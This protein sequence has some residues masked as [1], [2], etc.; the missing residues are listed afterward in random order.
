MCLERADLVKKKVTAMGGEVASKPAGMRRADVVD[1]GAQAVSENRGTEVIRRKKEDEAEQINI[2]RR[3]S[4]ISHQIRTPSS[5]INA[6]STTTTPKELR[7]P[8]WHDADGTFIA[9]LTTTQI[10]S[11]TV[12]PD[13]SPDQKAWEAK[14]E[15]VY[16]PS[17][18]WIPFEHFLSSSSNGGNTGTVARTGAAA[19]KVSQGIGANC[20][21]VAGLN[22][23][24]AHNARQRGS[25][26]LGVQNLV[27]VRV[28]AERGDPGNVEAG[29]KRY[30]RVKVFVN[31]AWTSVSALTAG[32]YHLFYLNFR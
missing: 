1:Q 22:V 3:S 15:N 5:N 29:G 17:C 30:W 16:S 18:P 9:P 28:K 14:W 19:V 21:V 32:V 26:T 25:R 31:G 27:D 8:L 11:L 13:F 23:L 6:S 24:V 12:R 20:S 10:D 4:V 2:L 7:L